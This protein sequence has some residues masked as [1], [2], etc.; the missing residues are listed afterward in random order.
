MR[1]SGS[2]Y[3]IQFSLRFLADADLRIP[4]IPFHAFATRRFFVSGSK[5]GQFVVLS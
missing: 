1:I 2:V 4:R 3:L 5:L